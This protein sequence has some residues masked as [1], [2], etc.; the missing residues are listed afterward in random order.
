VPGIDRIRFLTSN[1]MDLREEL[2][3][4]MGELPKACGYL[5]FPAQSGS[6]AVLRRMRRGYTRARYLELCARA[7]ELCPGIELA[8]DLI[9]G[10]PGES[11][12]EYLETRS[13]VSEVGFKQVYVFKYSVRPGTAAAGM[14]DDV[15]EEEKRRRN[16]DLL[17]LQEEISAGRHRAL[18]GTRA[19]VLVDG[20]TPRDASR[21]EGRDDGNR[22][23][24]FPGEESLTGSL[25]TVAV[26]R[27]TAA[28]L[29]GS[30]VPGTVR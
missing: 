22:T 15:P 3:A 27:A 10:F 13:L 26:E 24:I 18:A 17:D 2:L 6:D 29:Y 19:E 8:S 12:E 4:A 25:V 5:H 20:P 11:E 21:L 7:R 14:P 1:P 28:A 9:V 30:L 16:N 23:V